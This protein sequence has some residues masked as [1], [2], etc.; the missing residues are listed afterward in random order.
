MVIVTE[1]AKKSLEMIANKETTGNIVY[2]I[3]KEG[4]G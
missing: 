2:R 4:F 1:K 3:I